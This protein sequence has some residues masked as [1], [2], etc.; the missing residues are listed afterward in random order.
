MAF[1]IRANGMG[2]QRCN[3][4]EEVIV[5]HLAYLAKTLDQVECCDRKTSTA[6][7]HV[8]AHVVEH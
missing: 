4:R 8:R 2:H 6:S 7:R 3:L 5:G 1:T